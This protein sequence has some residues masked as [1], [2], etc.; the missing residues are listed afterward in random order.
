MLWSYSFV[1]EVGEIT[2]VHLKRSHQP[3]VSKAYT[4]S[5]HGVGIRECDGCFSLHPD[6][7]ELFAK[8]IAC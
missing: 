7:I 4:K 5:P 3:L 1:A 8:V 6:V 2:K